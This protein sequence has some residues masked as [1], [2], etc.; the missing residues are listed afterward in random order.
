MER[1]TT[2]QNTTEPTPGQGIRPEV[3]DDFEAF[4]RQ[5]VRDY[6]DRGWG[7][8]KGNFIAFAMASGQ[9]FGLAADTVKDGSSFKKAA[10]GAA[11]VVALRFALRHL[12]SGPLGL[13][14]SAAA[15]GS[16]VAYLVKNQKEISSK[17]S[18]YKAL[19]DD[20]RNQFESLQGRYR[21][22]KIGRPERD[23]MVEG[24]LKRL[25]EQVD[26]G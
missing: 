7:A 2:P 6:Y 19:I 3:Y 20:T 26:A 11:S 9:V 5:A 17:V 18:P 8:R 23:L 1:S 22:G 14:L 4:I 13:A 12:V 10:F 15:I 24:L 16:A 25:I 21:A